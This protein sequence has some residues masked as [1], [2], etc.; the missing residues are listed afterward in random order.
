MKK[1]QVNENCIGCGMCIA[2]DPEHFTFDEGLSKATNSEN[3]DSEQL[4][5][6]IES[7]PTGAIE[8]TECESCDNNCNCG[9]DCECEDCHCADG[10]ACKCEDCDCNDCKCDDCDC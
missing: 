5:N 4:K 2:I 7:C 9:D 8:L 3:L 1:L 6:A 10:E